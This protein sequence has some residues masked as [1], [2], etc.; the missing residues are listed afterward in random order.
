MLLL[1]VVLSLVTTT[2]SIDEMN[3]C[4]LPITLVAACVIDIVLLVVYYVI[5]NMLF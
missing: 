2:K 1:L 3:S 4:N 5:V